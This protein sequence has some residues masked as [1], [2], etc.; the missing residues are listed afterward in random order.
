METPAVHLGP[1]EGPLARTALLGSVAG[2]LLGRSAVVHLVRFLALHGQPAG[3]V[4]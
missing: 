1:A 4:R 3:V 2:A